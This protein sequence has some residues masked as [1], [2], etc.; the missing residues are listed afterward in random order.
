M[1]LLEPSDQPFIH[2]FDSFNVISIAGIHFAYNL[3]GQASSG[4]PCGRQEQRIVN[5]VS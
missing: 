4:K 3:Q 2:L 5:T 1:L